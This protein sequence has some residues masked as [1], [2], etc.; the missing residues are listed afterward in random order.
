MEQKKQAEKQ[1]KEINL[2][3]REGINHWA[4]IM[5]LADADEWA[6]NLNYFPRDIANATLIFQHVCS[7]VGIKNGR[8]KD[9][10]TAE[11]YGKRLRQLI[12]DMTGYDPAEIVGN[13]K[14]KDEV[15]REQ[16]TER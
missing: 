14:P 16:E 2:H 12:I 1:L 9:A 15:N 11:A 3:I 13:M 7:N 4:E 10:E 6:V 8:I 5:L